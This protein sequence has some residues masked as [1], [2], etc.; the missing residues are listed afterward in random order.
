M[1]RQGAQKTKKSAFTSTLEDDEHILGIL[2][3]LFTNLGSDSSPRIRLLAKF[4]EDDYE[5]VDR[6][7]EMRDSAESRVK[8]REGEL[9]DERRVLQSEGLELDNDDAYL[10]RLEAGLFSLQ[11]IN[12]IIAW[13]SMED[14]GVSSFSTPFLI[15][16]ELSRL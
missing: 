11:M 15:Q 8:A 4:V 3:S 7:L 13:I 12:Y 10:R 2:T 9:E 1:I 6:L 5:K 16:G 14:D